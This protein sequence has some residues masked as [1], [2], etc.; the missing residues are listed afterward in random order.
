MALPAFLTWLLGVMRGKPPLKDAVRDRHEKQADAARARATKLGV[1]YEA[2]PT[3]K[4]PTPPVRFM[5]ISGSVMEKVEFDGYW[6]RDLNLETDAGRI[7]L[8]NG[9]TRAFNRVQRRA[10]EA[11]RERRRRQKEKTK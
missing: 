1:I 5:A 7:R 3:P 10:R 9:M 4:D 11:E 6:F 2:Y 8:A